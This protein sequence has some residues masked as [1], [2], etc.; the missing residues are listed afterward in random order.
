MKILYIDRASGLEKEE[1]VYGGKYLQWLYGKGFVATLCS[2][3]CL[4]QLFQLPFFSWLYGQAQK[5]R[6]SRKKIAPFIT[7]FHID[8]TEFAVDS[9]AFTSFND[10]FIRKL[11]PSARPIDQREN[12]L[13][14]PADGRY[15]VF[16][17][18]EQV[19]DF[20]VKGKRWSLE[21]LLQDP[22]LA[23][24]Y[25]EG[26]MA[27]V[28]LC[29]T[30]YHRFH[31]PCAAKVGTPRQIPGGLASVN[32]IALERKSSLL[33]ENKRMITELRSPLFG[34]IQYI[35]VGATFVGSICQTFHKGECFKGEE[36]G[37]FEFGGSCLILLFEKER[38]EFD[39]DLIEASS[40]KK[41]V[42]GR[43]GSSLACCR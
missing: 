39:A 43:L 31:F 14:M 17:K 10:F 24:D 15:L 8:T 22:L 7:T 2:F 18:I 41:E 35:E 16:P 20:W 25:R 27:I 4:P 26:S 3:F 11:K 40:S 6:W 21:T 28:R 36:K 32:P 38:I 5:S 12:R 33:T 42:L 29:P 19:S 9:A 30:D 23:Q 13:I 37:Y 34:R 1:K